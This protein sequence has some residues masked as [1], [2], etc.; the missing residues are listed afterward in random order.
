MLVYLPSAAAMVSDIGKARIS[1]IMVEHCPAGYLLGGDALKAYKMVI[2]EE[3]S[4]IWVNS[5]SLPM[6]V[7]IMEGTRYDAHRIDS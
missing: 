2:D 5:V 1:K 4:A 3:K 6:K 7:P